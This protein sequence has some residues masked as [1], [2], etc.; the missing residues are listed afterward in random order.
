[1]LKKFQQDLRQYARTFLPIILTVLFG[2]QIMRVLIFSFVGYLRD[3]LN[4]GSLDLAPVAIGIFSL[5]LL[6][7]LINRFLGTKNALWLTSG[8]LAIIRLAEQFIRD[9]SIDYILSAIGVVLFLAFIP[10]ALGSARTQAASAPRHFALA[11]LLGLSLDS[12]IFIAANTLD[13]SWQTGF[14]ASGVVL[15]LVGVH[16]S[17]LS[18]YVSAAKAATDI[19]WKSAIAYLAFGPWLFLQFLLFQ[20]TGLFASLSGHTA[21]IAGFALLSS[22]AIAIFLL[23]RLG[24]IFKNILSLLISFILLASILY[25]LPQT[26]AIISILLLIIGQIASYT[27]L[28]GL[29]QITST[30][31]TSAGR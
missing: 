9:A 26:N 8:G 21:S 15:I 1:M 16:I 6:A 12:A 3:S 4:I 25:V 17:L 2:M 20:N 29:V 22:N 18:N 31:D 27:L 23:P 13:L 11:F 28:F 5:S 19:S 24:G 30:K 7:V 14:F 10:I